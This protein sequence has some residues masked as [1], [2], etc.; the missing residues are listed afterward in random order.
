MSDKKRVKRSRTKDRKEER[1]RQRKE[2]RKRR[3]ESQTDESSEESR[4]RGT[5]SCLG[6]V[7]PDPVAGTR[8]IAS[9]IQR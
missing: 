1:V 7:T 5:M 4:E 9:K 3:E 8:H 2:K 6:R